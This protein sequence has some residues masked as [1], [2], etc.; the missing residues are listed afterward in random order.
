[1][2]AISDLKEANTLLGYPSNLWQKTAKVF[3]QD[4]TFWQKIKDHYFAMTITFLK[5]HFTYT[6]LLMTLITELW[7]EWTKIIII[8]TFT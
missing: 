2:S 3:I 5:Y 7:T 6:N 4:L 1:M 8:L